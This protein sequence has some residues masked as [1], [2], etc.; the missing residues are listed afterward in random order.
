MLISPLLPS[1]TA[2]SNNQQRSEF[3]HTY[4]KSHSSAFVI[5]VDEHSQPKVG[6][7]GGGC[8]EGMVL[9]AQVG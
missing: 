2:R 5:P 9:P 4:R 3:P 1:L 7:A 8:G 6:G